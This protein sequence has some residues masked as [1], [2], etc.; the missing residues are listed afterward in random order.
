MIAPV[1]PDN[2]FE[3]LAE[4]RALSILDTPREERFDRITR[5]ASAVFAT[6]ISYIA[7]VDG[8]RQWFKSRCGISM[9]SG[10]R[11]ES[12]CGHAIL[13][14]EAL[15]V[16]DALR[17]DR[18][19]DNPL[20]T[21]DPGIRFYVGHP[22]K[23]PRGL[24]VGTLCLADRA[25][26]PGGFSG[27]ATLRDLVGFAERELNMIDLIDTQREL[28]HTKSNLVA[29]QQRLA[30]E[31]ESASTYV[32][33]LLPPTVKM[34]GMEVRVAYRPSTELSG[35]FV[36]ALALDE[37]RL[38]VY[39]L[40]ATGHGVAAA[41]LAVSVNSTIRDLVHRRSE[42]GDPGAILGALNQ[43]FRF[44]EQGARFV[45]MWYGII[46]VRTWTLTYATAG[47]NP[48]L[49]LRGSEARA[50]D[51]SGLPLGLAD[52]TE[53]E[54]HRVELHG[55]DQLLAFSDGIIELPLGDGAE[56]GVAG[57]AR[58]FGAM[59]HSSSFEPTH[60]ISAIAGLPGVGPFADD[61]SL[62]HVRVPR[63]GR[64]VRIMPG[65]RRGEFD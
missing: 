15:V 58:Q 27:V 5:L 11:S 1:A 35:D 18:F 36:G 22:I 55:G 30:A 49:L 53:Y 4:L 10:K 7:F 3:R 26:R 61:V 54:T 16:P 50:L 65:V 41:L 33:S 64:R 17:D 51:G 2:E 62:L 23:G 57:L 37:H 59:A 28:L 44:D 56:F 9:E 29:A 39:V 34:A 60:L 48:P 42:G 32:R 20:V 21:D 40:D 13:Q 38:A 47:H 46:D 19:H 14:E 43:N 52:Q 6:P 12:F 31:V 63:V 45:T 24:N 8:D 25:P